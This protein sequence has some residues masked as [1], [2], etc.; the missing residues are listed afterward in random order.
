MFESTKKKVATLNASSHYEDKKMRRNS[1]RYSRKNKAFIHPFERKVAKVLT[2][3]ERKKNTFPLINSFLFPFDF[4]S[5][6]SVSYKPFKNAVHNQRRVHVN[7][8]ITL[9]QPRQ[10]RVQAAREP[11]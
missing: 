11:R 4:S 6:L 7:Y 1:G 10:L 5:L 8:V 9:R 3:W 2:A